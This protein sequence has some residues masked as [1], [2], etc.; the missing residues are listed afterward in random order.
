MEKAGPHQ[1]PG[2]VVFCPPEDGSPGDIPRDY[3]ISCSAKRK[4]MAKNV[5]IKAA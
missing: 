4:I 1:A 2:P 3:G 5:E